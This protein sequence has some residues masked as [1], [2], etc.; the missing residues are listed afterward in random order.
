[1]KAII[2]I[3][4]LIIGWSDAI[5]CEKQVNVIDD[6]LWLYMSQVDYLEVSDRHWYQYLVKAVEYYN[7]VNGTDF[8]PHT[9]IDEYMKK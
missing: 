7:E 9:V 6:D 8:N 3:V 4:A 2:L 5:G 1:M